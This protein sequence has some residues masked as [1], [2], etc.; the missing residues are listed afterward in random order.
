MAG[1]QGRVSASWSRSSAVAFSF[2][3]VR[4]LGGLT[5]FPFEFNVVKAIV[6]I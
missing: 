5:F 2:A 4:F 1:N 3:T 6:N